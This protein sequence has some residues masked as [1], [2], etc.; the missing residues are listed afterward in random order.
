M[1]EQLV[2]A[3]QQNCD[4]KARLYGLPFAL[5]YPSNN[6]DEA[7]MYYQAYSIKLDLQVQGI[8][9]D[10]NGKPIETIYFYALSMQN[11][12]LNHQIS[13]SKEESENAKA[14]K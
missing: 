14:F 10:F 5:A 2:K 8:N 9:I 1:K 11:E 3:L 4:N 7:I 12:A 13:N 6:I